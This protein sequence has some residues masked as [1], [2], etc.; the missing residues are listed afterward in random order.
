VTAKQ[1]SHILGARAI[2]GRHLHF[3]KAQHQAV[4]GLVAL[5]LSG[6]L[7]AADSALTFSRTLGGKS[8]STVIN[9]I[10]TDP[11]GNIVVAGTTSAFDFPVTSGSSNSGTQ[12]AESLDSG[13]TW[14]P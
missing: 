11:S 7:S 2:P 5:L 13:N 4:T 12:I 1:S 8:G 9:V 3:Q 6:A 14:N 10:A